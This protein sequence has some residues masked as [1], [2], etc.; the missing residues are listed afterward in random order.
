VIEK[1]LGSLFYRNKN[2][3]LPKGTFLLPKCCSL[4]GGSS[5][6]G[7]QKE[8]VRIRRG[9][10]DAHSLGDRAKLRPSG[11]CKARRYN[12][13]LSGIN[14]VRK[15]QGEETQGGTPIAFSV[16]A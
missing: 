1:R 4:I 5:K 16:D 14:F 12:A 13:Y 2:P 7:N 10:F 3:A 9:E 15:K 8:I 11:N 6:Q